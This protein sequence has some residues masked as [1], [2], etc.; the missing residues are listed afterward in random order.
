M[1]ATWTQRDKDK[2]ISRV[3]VTIACGEYYGVVT[4]SENRKL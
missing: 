4:A 2:H 1:N 3:W